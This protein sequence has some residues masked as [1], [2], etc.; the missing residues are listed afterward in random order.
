L[1]KTLFKSIVAVNSM[2]YKNASV[3]VRLALVSLLFVAIS[4][5][6]ASPSAFAVNYTECPDGT[7]VA[8]PPGSDYNKVCASHM[9]TL[10]NNPAV[11]PAANC[12]RDGGCDLVKKYLNPAIGLLSAL[13]GVAVVVS[14][15][16][17]GIQYSASAGDPQKA[18]KAKDHIFNAV[19]ALVAF[20]FLFAFLEWLVPGGLLHK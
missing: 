7:S 16:A 1:I 20:I 4:G 14:I 13:V 17:G 2:K 10:Q 5:M 6:S 19:V 9:D 15:I 12:S 11:D 8:F 18:A 3:L